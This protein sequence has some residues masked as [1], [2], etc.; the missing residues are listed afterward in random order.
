MRYEDYPTIRRLAGTSVSN[1]LF[2][3][4]NN[5]T[6]HWNRIMYIGLNL[7]LYSQNHIPLCLKR[8]NYSIRMRLVHRMI[9]VCFARYA[10]AGV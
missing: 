3:P 2:Q 10:R 1:R 6:S 8:R 5:L 9:A 7:A 4:R